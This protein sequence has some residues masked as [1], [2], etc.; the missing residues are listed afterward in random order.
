MMADPVQQR[1]WL[2]VGLWCMC[3][4]AC[5]IAT[6][7]IGHLYQAPAPYAFDPQSWGYHAL[8]WI[9]WVHVG[10]SA[11]AAVTVVRLTRDWG[12]RVMAWGAI[13]FMLPVA[14]LL[15][16]FAEMAVMGV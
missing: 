14:Y 15:R 8:R 2:A 9:S 5:P 4:L 7:V 1:R 3:L 12:R 11:V 10:L 6:I 13:A 16:I